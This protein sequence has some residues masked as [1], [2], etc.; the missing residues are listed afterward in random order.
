MESDSKPIVAS[1]ANTDSGSRFHIVTVYYITTVRKAI[2]DYTIVILKMTNK[3]I[4]FYT[5]L[6]TIAVLKTTNK[7]CTLN[8]NRA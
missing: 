5:K 7:S 2:N 4:Q 3:N 1:F 6:Y 8:S